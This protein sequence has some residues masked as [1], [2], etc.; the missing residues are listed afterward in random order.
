MLAK[1]PQ[2]NAFTD[3]EQRR[4]ERSRNLFYVACSR[5]QEDL[6]L[7]FTTELPGGAMETLKEWVG[8]SN[9]IDVR[10]SPEGVPTNA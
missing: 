1:F 4:F 8:E 2:R 5:A 7:L 3:N 10:Y 9:I 6:V